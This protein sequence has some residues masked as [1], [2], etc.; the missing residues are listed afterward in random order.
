[1]R[2]VHA[3][4]LVLALGP[5]LPVS[6]EEFSGIAV[7]P[8]ARRDAAAD[9]YCKHFDAAGNASRCFRTTDAF[10]KVVAFY[11]KQ[12]GLKAPRFGQMKLPGSS[13]GVFCAKLQD[14]CTLTAMKGTQVVLDSPWT[15]QLDKPVPVEKFE[16]KDVLVRIVDKDLLFAALKQPK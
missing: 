5:A 11:A 16:N 12:K 2:T 14:D 13:T 10:D 8:G 6:A 7:Y 4:A 9:A 1:M 3:L 15:T